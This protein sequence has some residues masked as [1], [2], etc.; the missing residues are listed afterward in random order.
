VPPDDAPLSYET[1]PGGRPPA[2][3]RWPWFVIAAVA[4][5]SAAGYG[6]YF[7]GL[8]NFGTLVGI[9]EL[10][11]FGVVVLA[12]IVAGIRYGRQ[13]KDYFT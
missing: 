2:P 7:A 9:T 8:V 5:A 1:P 10:V 6:C 13:D 4:A 11:V 12:G 3:S